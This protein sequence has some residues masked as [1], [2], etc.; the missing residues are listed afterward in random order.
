L[1]D[2][3]GA[4]LVNRDADGKIH[5]KQTGLTW[6]PGEG[7]PSVGLLGFSLEFISAA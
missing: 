2:F 6:G 5:I 1:I 3:E 7:Q 4:A